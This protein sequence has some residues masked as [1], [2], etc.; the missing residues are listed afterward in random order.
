MGIAAMT[1]GITAL[2]IV[3]IIRA[4]QIFIPGPGI[5]KLA[6]VSSVSIVGLVLGIIA[7]VKS[8]PNKPMAVVGVVICSL[9]IIFSVLLWIIVFGH[10]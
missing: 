5:M 4:P 6:V 8:K 2:V 10:S 9:V 3:L 1:L 7:L